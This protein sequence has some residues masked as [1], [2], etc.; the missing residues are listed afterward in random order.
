MPPSLHHT[1]AGACDV[2]VVEDHSLPI[3]RFVVSLRHGAG[4]DPDGQ[5]GATRTMLDLMLR[6]TARQSRRDFS[7]KLEELGS[8]IF[9]QTGHEAALWRGACLTRHLDQTWAMLREALCEPAFDPNEHKDLVS[10]TVEELSAARD[11][12][13]TVAE[14][15]L[16]RALYAGHPFSRA[17]AGEIKDLVRLSPEDLRATFARRVAADQLIVGFAGDIA[18]DSAVRLAEALT[19]T[20]PRHA[21]PFVGL[22]NGHNP[23]GLHITVANKPERSQI[24]LRLGALTGVGRDPCALP[25]WLGA[26]AFGG[27]FTAPFTYAIR[28]ER[29][30]SYGASASFDYQRRYRAPFV[31]RTAPS[32]DDAID[33]VALELE[34][35]DDLATHGPAEEHIEHARAYLL[36]RYP[37]HFATATDVLIPALGYVLIDLPA[38]TVFSLP[39]TLAAIGTSEVQAATQAWLKAQALHVVLVADAATVTDKLQARFPQAT[40][41]VVDYKDGLALS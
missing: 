36:N 15:F 3:V 39:Q 10:E 22:P 38:D 2:L 29:G 35:F 27:T 1:K 34:L 23:D 30:W 14:I 11:D 5:S 7:N 33:C 17:S 37:L 41:Q 40:L 8:S 4:H 19:A 21:E 28:E 18:V 6:G 31:L 16:R 32:L 12:D 20:L 24:Q 26:V 13:D 25:F 9:A